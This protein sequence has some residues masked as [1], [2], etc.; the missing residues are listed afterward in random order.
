MRSSRG[1]H[2]GSSKLAGTGG[3]D[4]ETRPRDISPP[5]FVAECF[6]QK[7]RRPLHGRCGRIHAWGSIFGVAVAMETWK[8][9]LAF[10]WQQDG[11]INKLELNTFAVFLKRRSRSGN[12]QHTIFFHVLDSMVCRGALAKGRS[13]SKCLIRVLRRCSAL[14]L[15][16]DGYCYPLWTISAWNFADKPSRMHEKAA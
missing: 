13:S 9:V 11:H 10:P 15:A 12:K 1:G 14:M 6:V 4:Y 16:M 7:N 3:A 2:G 8:T 5:L